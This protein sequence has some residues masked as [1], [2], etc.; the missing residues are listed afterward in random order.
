MG[1]TGLATTF[2]SAPK[3][4]TL[5]HSQTGETKKR[6]G[7]IVPPSSDWPP[8]AAHSVK[9]RSFRGFESGDMNDRYAE[10]KG[11]GC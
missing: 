5:I 9:L 11:P 10:T 6:R 1:T 8:A 7:R 3:T 2:L 4:P